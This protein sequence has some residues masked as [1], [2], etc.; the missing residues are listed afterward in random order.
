MARPSQ[1]I[2]QA[3]LASGRALYPL[4]GYAGLSV[5]QI[6]DHASVNVGMFHYHFQSK[7]N[8]V[9]VL[10]QGLYDEV[11]QQLEAQA[12]QAGTAIERLREALCLLGRLMRNHGTWIGR[13]WADAGLGE[14]V[15]RLF[16]QHN[17]PRHMGLLLVLLQE[18]AQAGDLAQLPPM[19]R[20]GFLMGSVLA[21]MVLLPAAIQLQFLPA[22]MASTVDPDVFSDAAIAD[23]VNRA[24]AA[25]AWPALKPM[26]NK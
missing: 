17:A 12:A 10:L 4:H 2:D 23:R 3:L 6:C 9:S 20:F 22:H 13:V 14:E 8:Y 26:V 5:R 24:L 25:L 19:Q 11:F 21:P 1:N 16:L 18:A 15:P 7:N